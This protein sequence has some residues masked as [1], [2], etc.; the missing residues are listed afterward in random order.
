MQL[1]NFSWP[2]R[3]S[4]LFHRC[5]DKYKSGNSNFESYYSD[6]DLNFLQSFG[7]KTREFFDFVEDLADYGEP[8]LENAL[9]IAAARR[10]YLIYRLKG[11]LSSREILPS[12]LPGK[13]EELDGIVWLP[14]IIAKAKGKLRG[15]LHPDIM[16][17][18]G[19]DRN[20][21]KTHD[22]SP[23]DFLRTVWS[24]ERSDD[25]DGVIIDF[26]KRV[27]KA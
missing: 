7:Y 5:L 24:A 16:F 19:G 3:F 18:C 15:E 13:N 12:D 2:D 26:V 6:D 10:D 20:F 21:L 22:I 8:S 17:S 23:A 25:E 1:S 9:L 4:E 14:R 27:S 11:E